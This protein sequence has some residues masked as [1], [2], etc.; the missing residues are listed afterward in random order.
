MEHL[1]EFFRSSLRGPQIYEARS[2]EIAAAKAPLAT[3][4]YLPRNVDITMFY[5][6]H[7]EKKDFTA[8]APY[9]FDTDIFVPEITYWTI[10][11]LALFSRISQGDKDARKQ[12]EKDHTPRGRF[13][14]FTDQQTK[15]LLGSGIRVTVIDYSATH[16]AAGEIFSHFE[17]WGLLDK[18]VPSW[19]KTLDNIIG[20]AGVEA[21]LETRRENI[22]LASAGPRLQTLIDLDPK[23]SQQE[24]VKVLV[25][26][27]SAHSFFYPNFETL[28]SKTESVTI[29][30]IIDGEQVKYDHFDRLAHT[31]RTDV[32]TSKAE[33][34]ELAMR[35]LARVALRLNAIPMV[36]E[37]NDRQG[38]RFTLPSAEEMVERFEEEDIKRF[39]QRIVEKTGNNT[40]GLVT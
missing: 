21:Q 31:F 30:Q 28:A 26:Q 37:K 29:R 27:G 40:K 15:G 6:G 11:Q 25:Q 1:K 36:F 22:M 34:R 19:Q 35:S 17:N 10:D 3:R 2:S 23:L 9:L 13:N 33:R 16:S 39:H 7:D 8:L 18:V 12:L 4:P 14:G 24:R 38:L 5:G 32:Q 20:Y